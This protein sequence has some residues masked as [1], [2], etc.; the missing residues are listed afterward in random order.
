MI[1]LV[2]NLGSTSFKFK[3]F[4]MS[5]DEIVLAQGSADRIGN[6]PSRWTLQVGDH[7]ASG[8]AE[9]TSHGDAIDLH[10]AGLARSEGI[11]VDRIDAIGFKAVHG[12][13]ISGAVEVD[14]HVIATM[15]RFAD[16]APA[17][18]PPY[19]AAMTAFAER[20][21]GVRQIAAFET[22][23]HQTIPLARQAYAVPYEWLE[24]LGV[25]RYGFHGASHRYIGERIGQLQPDARRIISCHLG[26]S[27][28][29]C[30]M[31]DGRSVAT[32]M[33][34]TPQTGLP[35]GSRVGDIDM[36]ALLKLKAAGIEV[37]QALD[38]LGSRAGLLGLSGV[39]SDLRD[40]EAAAD[41]GDKRAGLA[42]DTLVESARHYLGAYL[43]V[44]NGTDAIAFTGGIGQNSARVRA[45]VLADLDY[46]GIVC[47]ASKN[48]QI[49]EVTDLRIEADTSQVA[50][51]V[52]QTNEELVVARQTADAL[53]QRTTAK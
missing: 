14:D 22:A 38:A 16:V 43:A 21:P 32:S 5:S 52:L 49:N 13:P 18:N 10:L 27:S 36:F 20:M 6:P 9:L 47:E 23:F 29:V 48:E 8:E 25:R 7:S 2:A 4:D 26:G 19:I 53:R 15:Q 45:A 34:L 41:K 44:L 17:H 51:Y 30:A 50:I 3:L 11:D 33:G 37:D 35:Q 39:S 24:E 31:R 1:V 12:G 42:I 40:I 46:A 28:S